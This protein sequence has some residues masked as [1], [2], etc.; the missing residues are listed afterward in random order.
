MGVIFEFHGTYGS[1]GN[2]FS[3]VDKAIFNSAALHAGFG[4]V[5]VNSA[6]TGYWDYQ[7]TY[8][9]NLDFQNVQATIKYLTTLGTMSSSDKLYSIGD[10]DGGY[11]SSA[12]SRALGFS[13]QALSIA[14]GLAPYF[15][16]SVNIPTVNGISHT[17]TPTIWALA[18]QDGT[19]GVSIG[20]LYPSVI[21]IGPAGIEQGYCNA[22]EIQSSVNPAPACN[23][24]IT[25]NPYQSSISNLN[26][27]INQPSPVYPARFAYVPGLST[28]NAQTIFIW[29]Q[30]QGCIDSNGKILANPYQS[31]EWNAN[32]VN[33]KCSQTPLLAQFGTASS[34]TYIG[35]T[36]DQAGDLDDQFILA[37]AEHKFM[38]E[39][40]GKILLFFESH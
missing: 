38:S 28:A 40:T 27:Y 4:I 12:V 9:N 13:A 32:P 18:Q 11:F 35:L 36:S 37:F 17:L 14:G 2:W 6:A 5:A 19:S 3:E 24:T 21:G 23:T 29:M 33:F 15:D 25:P 26:F 39:F 8:P 10:S 34:A 16:P 31:V 30:T 7:T 20:G 1:Y 22:M